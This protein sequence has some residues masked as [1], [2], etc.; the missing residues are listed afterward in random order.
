MQ[1][2]LLRVLETSEV[3]RVGATEPKKI[4]LRLVTATN[5]ELEKEIEAGRFREDLYYRI[6]VYPL[7][8][9]PLRERAED[10]APIV[11]H[12]LSAIARRE[13]RP[14]LRLT[15]AALEKLMAYPWPGN[16][17]ELVN[18]LERAVL[19]APDNAIDAEHIV[20][21]E[22]DA[23]RADRDADRVSRGEDE[24]R[25]RVLLAA[26]ADWRTATSRSPRSSARRRARRSTTRSSASSSIP[27]R[28]AA[29]A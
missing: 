27:R 17:R 22:R 5:R 9:P 25:A 18:L 2:K 16:V 14:A 19:L 4:K 24:V 23:G 20:V 28:T 8:V 3:Q 29:I 15:A 6:H 13:N 12:Q 21:H 1:A 11:T 10:I 7:H 26:A